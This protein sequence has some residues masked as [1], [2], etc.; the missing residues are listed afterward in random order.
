M[1]VAKLPGMSLTA[2]MT[3]E[4]VKE[5]PTRSSEADALRLALIHSILLL[6]EHEEPE[7]KNYCTFPLKDFEP[8]AGAFR[9]HKHPYFGEVEVMRGKLQGGNMTLFLP[10][11]HL[12]QALELS[13]D[14][15]SE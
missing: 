14:G 4:V 5:L 7:T 10:R 13:I 9:E 1:S 11:D 2:L 8:L 6:Q 12:V 15:D 3:N